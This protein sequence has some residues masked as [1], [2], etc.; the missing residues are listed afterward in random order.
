MNSLSINDKLTERKKELTCL[1]EISK[2]ISLANDIETKVLKE[3]INSIK[4][5]WKFN[6]DAIVEI[7]ILDYHLST[8]NLSKNTIFQTSFLTIPDADRG[9]IKVHYPQEKHDQNK[10]LIDEQLLLD[11]IAIEIENYIEKFRTLKQKA[12]LQKTIEQINRLSVVGKMATN[13]AH[14]INNP[15]GNILGYAELIKFN[16]TN[17]EIDSDI[18]IIINSVLYAREIIKK[19]MLFSSSTSYQVQINEIKPIINFVLLFLKQNF[20]EKEIKSELIFK[21]TIGKA[22]IDSVQITQVLFNL[23]INA[24]QASP[25]KSILKIII[26][27]NTKNLLISIEDQGSGIPED[28][29]PRI[30]EPFFTTKNI[31]D[32]CGLGLSIVQEIIKNHKGKIIVKNNFPTGTIF[33]IKLPL[34]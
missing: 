30:F 15:L 9:F 7:Q 25:K 12:S 28:I 21:S 5:A 18:T 34:S 1:Y 13:I 29:K 3:I 23:L 16:N 4:K 22:K 20:Q 14:E 32:G 19:T 11:T 31:Q 2:I 6:N 24:L 27:N 10:F 17:P 8:S 26:E 33:K